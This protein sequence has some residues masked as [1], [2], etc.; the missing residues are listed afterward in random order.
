MPDEIL[1]YP[2]AYYVMDRGYIDFVRLF[3]LHQQEDFLLFAPMNRSVRSATLSRV[4][5]PS[6][7]VKRA[8]LRSRIFE[9]GTW[10][11]CCD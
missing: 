1:V 2:G 11:T 6:Q 7:Q 9:V 5:D 4:R 8:A 10:E 3:R